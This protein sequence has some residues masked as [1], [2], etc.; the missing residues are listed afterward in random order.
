VKEAYEFSI[1]NPFLINEEELDN[2]MRELDKG[3][4]E[5]GSN[6]NASSRPLGG[7]LELH[8]P[9]DDSSQSEEKSNESSEGEEE[10]KNGMHGLKLGG[11]LSGF[12]AMRARGHRKSLMSVDLDRIA[13]DA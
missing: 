1:L 5:S 13:A 11:K 3:T 6:T 8:L 9:K 7:G 2:M 10:S 4:V 12:D